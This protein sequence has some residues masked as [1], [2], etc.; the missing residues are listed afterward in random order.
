MKSRLK[1][2]FNSPLVLTFAL[3]CSITTL[4]GYITGEKSTTLLFSTYTSSWSDPLTYVRLLTHVL[5]HSGM[6]HL[7][8]NMAYILLLGPALEEKYGW[9][10]LLIVILITALI[11]GLIHNLF[12]TRS[13]LLGASGVVFAFI[14]LTSFTD[15]REGEIPLTFI[16]IAIIYLGLQIW[17][18]ITVK[19]NVSQL[20][21]I[22]G[23]LVGSGAGYLLNKKNRNDGAVK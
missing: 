8:G 2:T 10:N 21:H 1:V 4:L 20:T 17:D 11:T 23:G 14:L 3:I 22:I 6:A 5:G 15:F 9:K 7:V 18:M 19:D 13:I 12:F 16:L